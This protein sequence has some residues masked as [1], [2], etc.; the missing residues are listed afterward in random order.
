MPKLSVVPNK[1]KLLVKPQERRKTESGLYI[2]ESSSSRVSSSQGTIVAV[3]PEVTFAKVTEDVIYTHHC[4]QL[5]ALDGENYLL[6]KEDDIWA[7]VEVTQ[8]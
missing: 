4:G 8:K 5:L 3:G 1:G 7:K 2:P 6:I